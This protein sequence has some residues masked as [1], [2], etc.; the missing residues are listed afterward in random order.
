M[1]ITKETLSRI[2]LEE[3]ESLDEKPSRQAK[4]QKKAQA[5]A[6]RRHARKKLLL[7]VRKVSQSKKPKN[8]NSLDFHPRNNQMLWKRN[9]LVIRKRAGKLNRIK[10]LLKPVKKINLV[11]NQKR[12]KKLAMKFKSSRKSYNRGL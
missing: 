2:I 10:L 12:Y 4:R 8:Q 3:L 7:L 6:K 5:K 9:Y 1:K 11:N